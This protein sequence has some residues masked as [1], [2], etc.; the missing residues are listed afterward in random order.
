M[1]TFLLKLLLG[2]LESCTSPAEQFFLDSFFSVGFNEMSSAGLMRVS[3]LIKILCGLPVDLFLLHGNFS[4]SRDQKWN[5]GPFMNILQD[6]TDCRCIYEHGW[7]LRRLDWLFAKN[8]ERIRIRK[9]RDW[10]KNELI[11]TL[12]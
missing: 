1:F 6:S 5:M 7:I 10:V 4:W 9:L 3:Q 2:L 11:E 8:R 12:I